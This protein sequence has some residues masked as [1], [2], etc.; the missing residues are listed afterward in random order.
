M[1]TLLLLA[2]VSWYGANFHGKE[3]ASGEIFNMNALTAAHKTMPFGTILK[4]TNPSNKRSVVVRIND[5]GPFVDGR[6]L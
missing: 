6:D 5:R 3:T 2:V 4:V 1:K